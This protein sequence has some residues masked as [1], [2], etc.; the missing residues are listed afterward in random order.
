MR[1]A[2]VADSNPRAEFLRRYANVAVRVGANVQPGQPVQVFAA[3]EHVPLARALGQSAWE[4]GAS[5]VQ[6]VYYDLYERYLLARFGKDAVL[7]R[8]PVVQRAMLEAALEHRGASVVVIGDEAY[9]MAYTAPV[10]GAAERDSP[11][12]LELGI[13]QSTVHVDFPI[14]GPDVEISAICGNGETVTVLHGDDWVL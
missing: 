14:G 11:A 1:D 7:E 4:A 2:D 12:Q 6:L 10:A 8:T 3:V 9:G 5:D 13:N